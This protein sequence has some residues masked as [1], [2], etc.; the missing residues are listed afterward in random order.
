MWVKRAWVVPV[1]FFSAFLLYPLIVLT[2]T[3]L[4]TETF[5]S[6]TSSGP[7]RIALIATVQSLMSVGLSLALGLPIAGVLT[8]YRFPGRTFLWALVTVPFVLPTVVVALGFQSLLGGILEPGILLVVLAHA[9]INIA[10]VVRIVGAQWSAINSQQLIVARTLGSNPWRV[11]WTVT[12]PHL[13]PSILASSCVVFVFS[14]TSLGIITILGD[15]TTTRTLEQ[16]ILRQ[17][18]VLLDFPGALAS[19]ILQL[20]VVSAALFIAARSRGAALTLRTGNSTQGNNLKFASTPTERTWVTVIAIVTAIF[21]IAP[22]ASIA[23]DSFTSRDGFT[24]TWW[25]SIPQASDTF[26]RLGS[27]LSALTLSLIIA[28]FTALIAAFVGGAAAIAVMGRNPLI[29][30]LSLI[31]LGLSAATV[32]LGT[33]LAFGRPPI[34]LRSTG[35]LI[36]IAHALVAVPLVVAIAAPVLRAADPRRMIVASSLGASRNRA[37]WTAY[38]GLTR[39]VMLAA[40]GLAGAVSL[41]EF[42][43]ASFLARAD[44][45]TVPLQIA[46]L[47]S[48]PGEQAYATATVLSVVLILAT[49]ALMLTVDRMNVRTAR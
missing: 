41:G 3:A 19:A 28:A 2:Q 11:F 22:I 46:K 34:D 49:L 6:L 1:V 26:S 31:P 7:W 25:E 15:G 27:P 20:L 13:K 38:G 35:L 21:V 44:S 42:G 4:T 14:F 47:L 17:S 40:G 9:Y 39:T 16:T 29:A 36:P 23:I 37:W 32:G 10:V 8:R 18:S 43:A 48:R 30:F 24:L 33:L 5:D 45:P 12:V